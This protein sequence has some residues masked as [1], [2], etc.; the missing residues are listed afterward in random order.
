MSFREITPLDTNEA[1]EDVIWLL[2]K[3][4]RHSE[5]KPRHN[6]ISLL[7]SALPVQVFILFYLNYYCNFSFGSDIQPYSGH[8]HFK[9]SQNSFL[10]LLLCHFSSCILYQFLFTTSLQRDLTNNLLLALLP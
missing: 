7:F 1:S 5:K 2:T 8:M 9:S 10:S 6:S 3:Q 4:D